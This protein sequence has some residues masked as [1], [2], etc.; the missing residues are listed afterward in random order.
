MGMMGSLS[1]LNPQGL[2]ALGP[3]ARQATRWAPAA[4]ALLCAW[5]IGHTAAAFFWTLVPTPAAARW[6]APPAAPAAEH[7][8]LVSSDS[9]AAAQ[10]LFGHSQVN[11]VGSSSA[12]APETVL[13]LQLLGILADERAHSQS[14]ALIRSGSDQEKP[15]AV[16]DAVV[17]GATVKAIF[18][19]RVLLLRNGELETLRMHRGDMNA[20]SSSPGAPATDANPGDSNA[21]KLAHI[22]SQLLNAP[23]DVDNF[24]HVSPVT[25]ANGAPTGYRVFPSNDPTLFEAEG[26]RPGD[27]VTAVNGQPLTDPAKALQLVNQLSS[28][29]TVTL[30]VVRGR[31]PP[32][33]I[34]LNFSQ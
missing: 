31:S 19:D 14:R 25:G 4:A 34:V 10:D 26:L 24:L 16:G 20:D 32:Q 29:Q 23:G 8:T 17:A 18:P 11:S 6:Q 21:Q 15:Y 7:P 27:L 9:L 12:P 5:L 1:T 3:H 28:A 22:R 30:T 13:D 33:S 2:A